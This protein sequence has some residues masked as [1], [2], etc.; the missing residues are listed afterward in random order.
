MTD[1]KL[2]VLLDIQSSSL[3]RQVQKN[4]LALRDVSV[5]E[6]SPDVGGD[7]LIIELSPSP[8]KDFQ[9]IQELLDAGTVGEVFLLSS[10]TEQEVL[11]RSIRVGVKEFLTLPLQDDELSKAVSKL[12]ARRRQQHGEAVSAREGKVITVVGSKGGAGTTTVAVNLA[13]S[14]T[15]KDPAKS[16]LLVDMNVNLGE[17]PLFLDFRPQYNWGDLAKN[18]KRMDETFMRNVLHQHST[19][20]SV[21]PGPEQVNGNI[22]E[23]RDLF[24]QMLTLLRS[25]FDMVVID[26]GHSLNDLSQ[27]AALASDTVFVVSQ[28]SLPYLANTNKVLGTLKHLLPAPEKRLRVIVNR[29]D[30]KVEVS[31]HEAENSLQTKIFWSLPADYKFA[32][33]AINQGKP[34]SQVGSRHKLN[35]SMQDLAA[36]VMPETSGKEGKKKWFSR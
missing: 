23:L 3:K 21:L 33:S 9:A 18:L 25:M 36:K 13:V 22:M 19:G 28:L 24:G 1:T 29:H 7:V 14:L 35:R 26:A 16:V 31:M 34:F 15:E 17:V 11:L 12:Q 10:S 30:K 2:T 4:L 32:T 5:L 6:Y 27:Q 8:E 20:L